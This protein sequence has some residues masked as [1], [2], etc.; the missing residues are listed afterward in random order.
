MT[1]DE[2][3]RRLRRLARRRG[4]AFEVDRQRGKGSHWVVQ[5]GNSKQPVPHARGS[6]I[7]L[8]TLHSILRALGVSSRDLE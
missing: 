1:R 5:F 3:I 7:K 4:L 6:D 8:G 2:L